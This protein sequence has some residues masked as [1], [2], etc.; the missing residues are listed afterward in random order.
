MKSHR[1]GMSPAAVEKI[2]A[3]NEFCAIIHGKSHL[4]QGKSGV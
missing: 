4:N 1:L 2:R 3:K